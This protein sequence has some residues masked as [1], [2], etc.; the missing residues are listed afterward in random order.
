M[1]N[2]TPPVWIGVNEASLLVG[3]SLSTIRR[4]LPEI[5]ESAPESIRREPIEG[6]GGE[7]VLLSRSYL[8]QRF[9]VK[10]PEPPGE[11]E[12]LPEGVG[13]AALVEILE[14]Q[15]NA[16]DRQIESLQ[17]DA[18]AKSRQIDEAQ[19]N[20]ADLAESL[21]QFAALN[22]GLQN[23]LMALTEKV[24]ERPEPAAPAGVAPQERR[25]SV[26]SSPVYFIAVAVAVS[27]IV[28]LLLYLVLS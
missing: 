13:P 16:K 26:L 8:V 24:A 12:S 27:L 5:E 2:Q 1:S 6:K 22:A 4:L 14:R 25:E 23:K 3:K 17:R 28:G 15:I 21:R 19:Q 20:A 18:E 11:E 10:E 9:G 7:R